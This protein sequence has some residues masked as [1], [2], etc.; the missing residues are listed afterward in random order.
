MKEYLPI[1]QIVVAIFLTIAVLLQKGA[2]AF[3]GGGFYLTR[4]GIEKKL[5]WLTIILGILFIVLALLN[6][7][8]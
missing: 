1:A 5:L 8:I 7:V 2:P 4:R 6:L 3:G